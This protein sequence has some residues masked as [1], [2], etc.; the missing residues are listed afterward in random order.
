MNCDFNKACYYLM[1][2]KFG[3]TGFVNAGKV[4]ENET[5]R[6]CKFSGKYVFL[7]YRKAWSG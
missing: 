2:S 3:D 6:W 4:Q 1:I 7:S 5:L